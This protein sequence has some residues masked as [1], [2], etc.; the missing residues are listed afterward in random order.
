MKKISILCMLILHG[1]SFAQLK[2]PFAES[3]VILEVTPSK[4][5]PRITE[6]DTPH[7]VVYDPTVKQGKLLLFMPGTNGIALKGPKDLFATAVDQ[8]YYLINLSYI[9]TPAIARIC[10]GETLEGNSDCASDFRTNRI[11]G[12]NDFPHTDDQ[13]YDAII[14]R[15]TKLLVYLAENDKKG[16]WGTYLENGSPKWDQIAVAGQSQG[17]GM[18]AFIA[19]RHRVARVID[20]SGGWDYSAKN[21]IA[22]WYFN[23]SITPADR[24]YGTYH[25]EEGAAKTIIETYKAMNIPQNH[26]YA[27]NLPYPEGKR[28]HSNGIR[29]LAYKDL[30]IEMLGKGN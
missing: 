3:N 13:S 29:N 9:N 18:A 5:D 11:Y 7:F 20:F 8:G 28:P 22:K 12:T 17:G 21:K 4:T 30:W 25:V 1:F 24:W 14:N 2:S 19:K 16:N 27:F 23:E 26:V 6:A 10:K 15:F